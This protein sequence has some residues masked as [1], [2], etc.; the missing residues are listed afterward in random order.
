MSC[1]YEFLPSA[2]STDLEV[3]ACAAGPGSPL[4]RRFSG[5]SPP[6][7]PDVGW[8]RTDLAM[9]ALP[10]PP[11]QSGITN[12]QVPSS[13]FLDRSQSPERTIC[14]VVLHYIPLA[15]S[16]A[17]TP[18]FQAEIAAQSN[19]AFHAIWSNQIVPSRS[20]NQ[21]ACRVQ[22]SPF[23]CAIAA[24]TSALAAHCATDSVSAPSRPHMSFRTISTSTPNTSDKAWA[25]RSKPAAGSEVCNG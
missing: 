1:A 8:L 15:S 3:P 22:P 6:G 18:E 11:D 10:A 20:V 7:R 17:S 9:L 19:Q 14:A 16:M 2:H 25:S 13:A 5:L 21:Q 12:L 4:C 24:S 23:P